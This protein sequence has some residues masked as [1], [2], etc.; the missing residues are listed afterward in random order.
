MSL[1]TQCMVVGYLQGE[2]LPLALTNTR[3]LRIAREYVE[4]VDPDYIEHLINYYDAI[5]DFSYEHDYRIGVLSIQ[6]LKVYLSSKSLTKF[7]LEHGM[8]DVNVKLMNLAAK[9]GYFDS[10]KILRAQG[11]PCPW[12]GR[13]CYN[14]ARGGHLDVLQWARSQDPPCP[15]DEWACSGAAARGHLHVLQ[16]A[17]SQDPPCP[18]D[19]FYVPEE[20]DELDEYYPG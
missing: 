19:D 4:P 10:V 18:W 15:W 3:L 5:G 6:R 1:S 17:R 20:W 12:N 7:V 13:A 14:A 8:V 9:H 2:E 11:P 16:W